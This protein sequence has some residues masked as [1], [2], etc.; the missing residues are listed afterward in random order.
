VTL[1]FNTGFTRT[2]KMPPS[3]RKAAPKSQDTGTPAIHGSG[4][5]VGEI[6]PDPHSALS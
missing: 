6:V 3:R 4:S 2:R 1:P 5:S